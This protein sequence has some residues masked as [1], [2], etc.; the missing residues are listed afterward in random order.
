MAV[1]RNLEST[2]Y[3]VIFGRGNIVEIEL[4]D[5]ENM[6]LREIGDKHF[7][8]NDI[9]TT[10]ALAIMQKTEKVD[11][12]KVNRAILERWSHSALVYI[13]NRAWAIAEGRHNPAKRRN[14]ND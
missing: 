14:E 11:W 12:A 7:Y 2:G 13:K 8:R 5:C 6:L 1:K 4:C 9:A 3:E 10:Y